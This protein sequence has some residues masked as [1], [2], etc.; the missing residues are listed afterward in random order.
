GL[1]DGAWRRQQELDLQIALAPVLA[2]TKGFAAN[3]VREVLS[4]ARAL[5]EQID[6][7]QYLVPLMDGLWAFHFTRAEHK[8][9]LT[10]A[11]QIEKH[12]KARND[13]AVQLLGYRSQ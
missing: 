5:A 11:K 1:P 8:L 9:A 2:A 3:D 6:R 4:R 12:G 7:P 10:V 13:A